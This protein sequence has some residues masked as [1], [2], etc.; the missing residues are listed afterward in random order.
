MPLS[1]DLIQRFK[2]PFSH[3]TSNGAKK[4][5]K[6]HY[7]YM[8]VPQLFSLELILPICGFKA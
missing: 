7:K 8:R 5:A 2:Y 6:L 3:N 4:M 1:A